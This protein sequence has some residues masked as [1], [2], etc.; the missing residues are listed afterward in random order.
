LKGTGFGV[1][2][3]TFYLKGT[4]FSLYIDPNKTQ[5]VQALSG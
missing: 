4:G 5:R 1:K 3:K 2:G